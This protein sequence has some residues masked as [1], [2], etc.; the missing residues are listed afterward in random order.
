MTFCKDLKWIILAKEEIKSLEHIISFFLIIIGI[1]T[2]LHIS[3]SSKLIQMIVLMSIGTIRNM[4]YYQIIAYNILILAWPMVCLIITYDSIYKDL[5]TE[6]IRLIITKIRRMDY[7]I[8]K[9]VSRLIIILLS[10]TLIT[11]FIASYSYITVGNFFWTGSLHIF[12][13]FSLMSIFL[14]S[15]FILIS[16]ISKN[17]LFVSILVPIISLIFTSMPNTLRKYS[18]YTYLNIDSIQLNQLIFYVCGAMILIMTTIFYFNRK[19]L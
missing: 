13:I 17:P 3:F 2:L 5:E 18:F 14:C 16:T 12:I 6:H 11:L 9:L 7:I 10:L 19:K 15:F 4:S 1:I 8:A